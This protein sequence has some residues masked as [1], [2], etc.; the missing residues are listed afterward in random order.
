MMKLAMTAFLPGLQPAIGLNQRNKL[1]NF[2]SPKVSHF[3]LKY[4]PLR[5]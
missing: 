2:Y 3:P 1:L 5:F 4:P